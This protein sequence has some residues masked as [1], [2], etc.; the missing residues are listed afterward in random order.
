MTS[1]EDFM[2]RV[3]FNL[4]AVLG[5]ALLA[6]SMSQAAQAN[7]YI[8]FG[9]TTGGGTIA[10]SGGN[11]TGTSIQIGNMVVGDAP[12]NNGTFPVTGGL[13]NFNTA[14]GTW[15]ITGAVG[16]I[17]GVSGSLMSGSGDVFTVTTGTGFVDVGAAGPD[18]LSAALASALGI[19]YNNFVI[20]FYLAGGNGGNGQFT[21]TSTDINSSQTPEPGTLVMFGS[22]LLGLAGIVRR[23]LRA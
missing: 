17:P 21:A 8:D 13:L 23:K 3:V 2:K 14:A 10:V 9:S 18:S 12:A 15:S 1:R 11:A 6:L 19:T 5:T 4:A 16:T 20:N 22:G 7:A